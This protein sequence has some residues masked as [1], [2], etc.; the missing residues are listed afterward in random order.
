MRHL[1]QHPCLTAH[2]DEDESEDDQNGKGDEE[3]EHGGIVGVGRA[4]CL[5][6][7]AGQGGR[8]IV[9]VRSR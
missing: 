8:V 7:T 5:R 9:D 2:Y 6:D 1:P 4:H 3:K